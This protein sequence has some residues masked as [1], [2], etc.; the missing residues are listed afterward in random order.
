LVKR[1]YQYVAKETFGTLQFKIGEHDV[2]LE[3]EWELF[4]Y[5][6]TI[7]K[8]T[9]VDINAASLEDIE[10]ALK[11]HKVSYD[12]KGWNKNRAIDTLW[13]FCR[14]QIMGPGF[15]VGVP[16]EISPLAKSDPDRPGVVE[17]FQPLIAGSEMG[18]GYSELN[19]PLDQAERFQ[20]QSKL[21]DAGDEEAQMYDKEFVEALEYGMPPTCGFGV[22][23]RFF[24]FLA[25]RPIRE[26][27]TFPLM[28][29]KVD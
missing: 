11:K 10:A 5:A 7:Q 12:K 23:E 16:K 29:P 1:L 2:D 21:R 25:N 9:G 17:R 28:R 4:D 8:F 14:K 13:K 15:L 6:E 3:K 24:S 19:D 22:S 26:T 27:Q 18:N 20:E